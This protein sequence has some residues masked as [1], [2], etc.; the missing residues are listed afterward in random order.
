LKVIASVA[1]SLLAATSGGAASLDD[2][3]AMVTGN[4]VLELA[5]TR[6][7][8]FASD[9][10]VSD[11]SI[12][13]DGRSVVYAT[14]TDSTISIGL[15]K[16]TGGKPTVLLATP[17]GISSVDIT[18]VTADKPVWVI[19]GSP[20]WSPNG[21]YIAFPASQMAREGEVVSQ[22]PFL[23]LLT[24]RGAQEAAIPAPETARSVAPLF[25]PD[26]TKV[27]WLDEVWRP[28]GGSDGR[29]L[30]VLD[31]ERRTCTLIYSAPVF[32]ARWS[33]D[34]ASVLLWT[35]KANSDGLRTYL[36]VRLDGTQEETG[37]WKVARIDPRSPDGKFEVVR[38]EPGLAVKEVATGRVLPLTAVRTSTCRGWLPASRDFCYTENLVAKNDENG[39]SREFCTLWLANV[40]APKLNTMLVARDYVGGWPSW[41]NDG[42]RIAYVVD[43]TVHVAILTRRD[44]T[45]REKVRAGLPVTREEE[46]QVMMEN[47]KTIGNALAMFAADWDDN[48][49]T[50]DYSQRLWEEHGHDLGATAEE[51]LRPYL[52]SLGNRDAFLRPGTQDVIFRFLD[53][54]V[55]KLTDIERPS[56][57]VIG[58][59]DAGDGLVIQIFADGHVTMKQR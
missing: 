39:R 47:G 44:A 54:G 48:L 11:V 12:S 21:K 3:S 34:G 37:E 2:Y 16:T 24:N 23:I 30:F 40:E 51:A 22:K 10:K 8:T 1:L 36:R 43:G 29:D 42:L 31:I 49:P 45:P 7:L 38:Q 14:S 4:G 56:E 33:P 59:L 9:G 26:S 17:S 13:P 35:T 46:L 27:L 50:A 57:T 20:V 58:E 41:S 6:Q 19:G 15:V 28:V 25:S 32:R 53:P 52:G 5:E 18:T 55:A